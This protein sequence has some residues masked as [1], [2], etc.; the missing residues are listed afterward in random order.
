[1]SKIDVIADK[2]SQ[3]YPE[4]E[5]LLIKEAEQQEPMKE[6][7]FELSEEIR[8]HYIQEG[9]E[10][11]RQIC[12]KII[13][14]PE[15]EEQFW[16]KI[17]GSLKTYHDVE[18]L[19]QIEDVDIIRGEMILD[20]IFEKGILRIELGL[21]EQYG[22]FGFPNEDSFAN[23][24]LSLKEL[25]LYYVGKN[26]SDKSIFEDIREETGFSNEFCHYFVILLNKYRQELRWGVL[27]E[28][29]DN[30][31]WRIGRLEEKIKKG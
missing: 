6:L 21:F 27:L 26:W 19:R 17:E 1:M 2:L 9:A 10:S 20:S 18:A 23:L 15:S 7:L 11:A 29:L 30:I 14:E 4:W 13:H 12:K 8:R 3:R 22:Q 31:R 28:R 24:I 5:T 25:S 16:N